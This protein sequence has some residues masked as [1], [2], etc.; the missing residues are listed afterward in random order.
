M[1]SAQVAV[2]IGRIIER[3]TTEAGGPPTLCVS[4]LAEGADRVVAEQALAVPRATLEVIMP[5]ERDDYATDFT[6]PESRRHFAGLLDRA[7]AVREIKGSK[8]RDKADEAAGRAVVDRCDVLIAISDGKRSGGRGGALKTMMHARKM[9]VP[10]FEISSFA[11]FEIK[12]PFGK[13]P[14]RAK[15]RE[16]RRGGREL[17]PAQH[18]IDKVVKKQ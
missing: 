15:R 6:E 17:R 12:D 10:I 5:L 9:Q 2:A 8:S 1:I 7:R 4:A 16:E 14:T 11:P 13:R 18:R 3:F